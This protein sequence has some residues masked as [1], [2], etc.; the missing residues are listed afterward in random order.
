MII[1]SYDFDSQASLHPRAEFQF[2][3]VEKV[4]VPYLGAGGGV[5]ENSFSKIA[6]EN[7]FMRPDSKVANSINQFDAYAGIKGNYTEHLAFDLRVAYGITKDMYFFINDTL[8]APGNFMD[9]LYDDAELSAFYA[10]FTYTGKP[11]SLTG[12]FG[13]YGYKLQQLDKPWHKPDYTVDVASAYSLNDKIIVSLGMQLTGNR[14]APVFNTPGQS[15]I[16]LKAVADF[17]LGVEYRYTKI[18]SGF[19]R[20]SNIST[21]KYYLYQQY[22]GFGFQVMAGF[23]YSL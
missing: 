17:N 21:S 3:I 16:K 22:P 14:Y 7:P 18:L 13:L 6:L 23:T 5:E 1:R 12:R 11:F 15:M 19:V 9:V 2:N 10:S 8:S 4:L 20:F